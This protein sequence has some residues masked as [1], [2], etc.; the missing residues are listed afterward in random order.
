MSNSIAR[1]FPRSP[2]LQRNPSSPISLSTDAAIPS[3]SCGSC[4]KPFSDSTMASRAPSTFVATRG[5]PHAMASENTQG[6]PSH[7]DVR[8]T[9][10]RL[11]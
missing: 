11:R 7:R 1:L 8:T 9:M 10:S 6:K 4:K 5:S 2:I 3:T